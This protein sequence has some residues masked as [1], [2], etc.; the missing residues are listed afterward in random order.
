MVRLRFNAIFGQPL[1]DALGGFAR[2]AIND[3]ALSWPRAKKAHDLFIRLFLAQ[4]AI[5][6]VRPVKTGDVATGLAQL[7]KFDNVLA[8]TFRRRRGQGHHRDRGEVLAQG[9][10]LTIFRTEI[11]TPL[12]DTMGLVHRQQV[13]F[14]SQQIGQEP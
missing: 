7:E 4:D 13:N 3:P 8:D 10:E 11:M 6:K 9:G 14:P 2:L 5:G 12:A 1:G